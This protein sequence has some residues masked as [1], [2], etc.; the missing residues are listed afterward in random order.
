MPA[1]RAAEWVRGQGV[2]EEVGPD[3]CRVRA[4]S[5]S[6]GALAAWLGMFDV[7]LEIVGPEELRRAAADLGRRYTAA[8]A[9]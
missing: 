4:G 9:G 5:W 2:V 1:A 7:D 8:A 3:R 6:W